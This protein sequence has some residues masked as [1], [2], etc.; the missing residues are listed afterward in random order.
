MGF[1]IEYTLRNVEPKGSP[2]GT[3]TT[4]Q[5]KETLPNLTAAE[6]RAKEVLRLDNIFG[7]VQFW[8]RGRLS[9]WLDGVTTWR[10]G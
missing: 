5:V 1:T 6:T 10:T 2:T 8:G 9:R 3:V 4:Q 7:S